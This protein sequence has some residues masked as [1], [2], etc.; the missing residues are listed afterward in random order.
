[1]KFL[2]SIHL[3]YGKVAFELAKSGREA[4]NVI[5]IDEQRRRGEGKQVVKW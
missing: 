4:E 1:V 2:W 3:A 5:V